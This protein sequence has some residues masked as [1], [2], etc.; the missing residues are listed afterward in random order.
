MGLFENHYQYNVEKGK[1]E[2]IFT[3]Y[4]NKEKHFNELEFFCKTHNQLCCIAC[5]SKIKNKY[6]GQHTDCDICNIELIKEEKLKK[7]KE[8][9]KNLENLS[10]TLVQKIEE[11]KKIFEKLNEKK[12]SLILEIQKIFTNIRNTLN[13]REDQ[14]IQEIN[15]KFDNLLCNEKIIKESEK[16]PSKVKRFLEKSKLIDGI[17]NQNKLNYLIN[18]CI[19]IEN[20][21]K[22]INK[23]NENIEKSNDL[24]NIKIIFIQKKDEINK[25]LE[26]IKNFGDI[27]ENLNLS[28]SII[29]Y[30][31]D[32]Y[33]LEERL[34]K[35]I[36]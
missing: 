6:Y 8:N 26:Q 21:I 33:F 36:L 31:K 14:L 1:N 12:E 16:L 18:D 34:K 27:D 23:I 22:E 7:L 11:L 17:S 24:N 9:K 10:N 3:G 25:L 20:N 29:K 32:I 35:K 2:D 28:S 15:K 13:D 4:C 30:K 19:L 5:I